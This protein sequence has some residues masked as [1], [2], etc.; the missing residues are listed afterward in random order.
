MDWQ[1]ISLEEGETQRTLCDCCRKTTTEALGDLSIGTRYL[2]WYTARFSEDQLEHPPLLT[3]YTGDWSENAPINSRWGIRTIWHS[4][5][6]ELLDWSQDDRNRIKSFTPLGREDV[7][8]TPFA[9]E[10]WAM[11]DAIIMKDSRLQELHSE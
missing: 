10:Y 8:S 3:I 5:G 6:C 4:E 2:G 9:A 11:V 7:L 1:S